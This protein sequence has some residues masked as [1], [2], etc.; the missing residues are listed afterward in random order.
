MAHPKKIKQFLFSVTVKNCSL[1]SHRAACGETYDSASRV[2]PCRLSC[3]LWSSALILTAS[4][5]LPVWLPGCKSQLW[6]VQ[7]RV[8]PS[9]NLSSSGRHW[10]LEEVWLPFPCRWKMRL[11][12]RTAGPSLT[13]SF[14][15][16][17]EPQTNKQH[18]NTA[19]AAA[20]AAAIIT[21]VKTYA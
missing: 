6:Q 19:A 16:T 14:T 7:C 12:L 18:W 4:V 17:A 13:V 5:R 8:R 11:K 15:Q 1:L 9:F 2:G 10:D 3:S 20:A 21:S